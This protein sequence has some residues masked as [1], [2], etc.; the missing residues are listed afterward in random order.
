MDAL[1]KLK[2]DLEKQY[3]EESVVYASEIPGYEIVSSGSLSLDLA[4]G[5][6]GL[7]NNRVIEIV[8]REGVGKTTLGFHMMKSFLERYPDKIAVMCDLEHRVTSSWMKSLIGTELMERIL[9]LWPDSAEQATDMYTESLKSGVVSVFM[10]DSIGGSPTQRVTD[11]SATIGN[12]G[13]NAQAMTRFSQF[14]SI[15]SHKYDCLTIC[16]NQIRDDISGYNRLIT[17]GGHGLK[18]CYSLRIELKPGKDKFYDMIDGEKVQVGGEVMVKMVKNSLAT[19][20][21][22]TH[23]LFYYTPSKY[24]F[25]IDTIEETIRL[26]VLSGVISKGGRWYSHPLLPEGKVGSSAELLDVIKSHDDVREGIINEIT[27]SLAKQKVSGITTT[28]DPDDIEDGIGANLSS[29][30]DIYSME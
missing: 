20:Y 19:P 13:G 24:G 6:G 14:A 23:Y 29:I 28:F 7:P 16:I 3:G 11:K 15:Y 17:P 9:L 30:G 26:G 5:I 2:R 18:H 1:A 4:T 21:K 12:I 25:G 10:Y 8:G 27:D 22:S